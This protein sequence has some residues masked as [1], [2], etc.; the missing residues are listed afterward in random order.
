MDSS[1]ADSLTGA[2]LKESGSNHDSPRNDLSILEQRVSIAEQKAAALKT[3]LESARAGYWEWDIEHDTFS[4]YSQWAAIT[5]NTPDEFGSLTLEK[6]RE[7]CHPD[8]IDKVNRVIEKYLTDGAEFIELELRVRHKAGGWI[9]VLDRGK[10]TRRDNNGKPLILTGSRQARFNLQKQ[11]SGS[12]ETIAPE[13]LLSLIDNIPGA[14]YH[15]DASGQTTSRSNT[16]DFMKA[17]L[18]ERH[19]A[20]LFN[21]LSMIH[22]D[23]RQMVTEAYRKLKEAKTSL[24]LVYRAVTPEGK[25]RW[26]EDHKRSLFSEAGEYTGIDGILCDISNRISTQEETRRLESQL[27]K[28][29]RLE[30]I[31]TLAGGIAHDFN[32]ILTP[33][34]GYAEMGI[35]SI[36]E[37]DP[38]HEYFNEIM[39]AAERA[40]NL[41]AQ[42]LT[43][44]RAE[45]GK[46]APVSLQIVITEALQFLRSSLPSTISIIRA[47]KFS[48]TPHRCIRSLSIFAPMLFMQ[49]SKPAAH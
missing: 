19:G 5:G 9:A 32:N 39:Q 38:M 12:Q 29:Q 42:I 26:I 14:I 3:A 43:F 35:S 10:I 30:T 8:D 46:V 15:I 49:W 11:E 2:D 48:L 18:S 31:G 25:L 21:T 44:S 4:I 33:I 20:H 37:D 6:W 1:K 36:A 22:A 41:V 27:R 28:S 47:V 24:T 45:E 23:D 17:L 16:P 13:E 34:L 7:L 40:K